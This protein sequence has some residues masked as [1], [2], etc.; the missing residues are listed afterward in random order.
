MEHKCHRIIPVSTIIIHAK[1]KNLFD[2]LNATDPDPNVTF[3]MTPRI[4]QP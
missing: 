3:D 4:P 2:K 1:V